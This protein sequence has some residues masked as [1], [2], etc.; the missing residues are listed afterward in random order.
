MIQ[1]SYIYWIVSNSEIHGMLKDPSVLST[2]RDG[3]RKSTVRLAGRHP[4]LS[5][6]TP[7]GIHHNAQLV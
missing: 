7:K 6:F 1:I 3:R 2:S 5:L 4:S